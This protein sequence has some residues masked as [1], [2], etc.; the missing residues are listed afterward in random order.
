MS[1]KD[2]QL[3]MELLQT[4]ILNCSDEQVNRFLAL[5]AMHNCVVIYLS[6]RPA[7]KPWFEGK[8]KNEIDMLVAAIEGEV[9]Q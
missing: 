6:E 2:S 8:L 9:E 5:L 3:L 1:K 4:V 7:L